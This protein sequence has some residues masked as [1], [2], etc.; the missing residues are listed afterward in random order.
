MNRRLRDIFAPVFLLFEL[1]TIVLCLRNKAIQ[2]TVNIEILLARSLLAE[3]LQE[4]LR[5]EADVR[6]T[7][8]A[9]TDAL[10]ATAKSF[11][12]LESAYAE[13]DLKGFENS[14]M[15]AYLQHVFEKRLHRV[16]KEFFLSFVDVRNIMILYKQLRWEIED[17]SPF[18]SGGAI[19]PACFQEILA[20]KDPA[21]LDALVTRVT[22]LKTLTI[23]STEGAVET[24]LLA[25]LT[26]KL[27]KTGR[28]FA[29]VGLILDYVWR[30]Y[31]HARNLAVLY[32]GNGLDA[33][34]LE[35]ELVR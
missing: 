13:E 31:I 14:L 17:G 8:A 2:R 26:R 25:S 22:G 35:R 19:E 11:R 7:I 10:A 12:E 1:K 6:S 30:I 15:R 33:E 34:T 28:E 24:A 23:A 21:E 27:Q 29:H 16:I 18:I 5:R 4:L 20:R 3:H 32:H 9:L